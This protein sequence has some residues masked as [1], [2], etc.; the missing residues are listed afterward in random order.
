MLADSLAR[1]VAACA[2]GKRVTITF[3]SGKALVLPIVP[4]PPAPPPPPHPLE[5]VSQQLRES[6]AASRE[7]VARVHE[8]MASVAEGQAQLAQGM[9]EVVETLH[10]PV[11][12]LL[13][14]AGKLIGAKRVANLG[15]SK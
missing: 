12:P 9:R 4:E 1:A 7:L 3:A 8:S 5:V 13:D 6:E 2:P 11:K 10:L 15:A 14:T